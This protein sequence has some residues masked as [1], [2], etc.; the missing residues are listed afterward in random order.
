MDYVG[1]RLGNYRLVRPVGRGAFADVYLGEH[2]HL[3]TQAAVKVLHT[4]MTPEDVEK[5]R[6]E[7][8]L[9]VRLEHPHII[10]V[11]DFGVEKETIPFLVM[12]YAPNGTLRALYPRGTQLPLATVISYVK[13]IAPALQYAHYRKVIHRDIKPENILLGAHNEILL[14]DFGI[15]TVVQSTSSLSTQKEAGTIAYMAPEQ[16]R[17]KVGPAS[18]QYALGVL[19][20]EWLSGAR[21]F[22]GDSFIDV[23]MQHV[24]DAPPPLRES[25]PLLEPA[26][27]LV[28]MQ[29]LAKDPKD[30][31]PSVQAFAKALEQAG[32]SSQS[33]TQFMSSPII[34]PSPPEAFQEATVQDNQNYTS[35]VQTDTARLLQDA[36]DMYRRGRLD[37]AATLYRSVLQMDKTN[38]RA[39]QELGLVENQRAKYQDAL[40]SFECALQLNSSLIAALNGKATS[41]GMLQRNQEALET[42]EHVL[43]LDAQNITAWSGKGSALSLLQRHQ[44]ALASFEHVLQMEPDNA[45]A[46]NGKGI[47]LNA[48]AHPEQALAAFDMALH[49]QPQ[50]AQAWSNKGLIYLQQAR[51]QEAL[52][53]FEHA[54]AQDDRPVAYWRGKGA[55][56]L[57]QGHLKEALE[58]YQEALGRNPDYV[59]ALYGIGNV[60]AQQR[61]Y[62]AALDMYDHALLCDPRFVPALE[63]RAAILNDMGRLEESLAAYEQALRLHPRYAHAWSGKAS[64]LQQMQQY[65]QALAAYEQA[66]SINPTM[67]LVWNGKGNTLYQLGNFPGALSCYDQALRLDPGMA[68]ALHNK[69]LILISTRQYAEGLAAAEVAIQLAPD[70]P[71]N[72]QRKADALRK[73]GKGREA[74]AAEE[75]MKRLISRQ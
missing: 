25:L 59:P 51:N 61:K 11:L 74:R 57:A 5:F 33:S 38:A 45:F 26:V 71:D 55:T 39:W 46:W 36:R 19:V 22:E 9:L 50:M 30:R 48:L 15:A 32:M 44:E 42:Y 8:R 68:L 49:W 28:V 34:L 24:S 75:K 37:E 53:A 69:A 12:T 65:E 70:D 14:S 31:F 7:A 64:V 4:Q 52:E 63:K 47:A 27:E 62:K 10:R 1:Q 40:A 20:Y 60:L 56:L 13:Q 67:P 35:Q 23:A 43:L 72:W 2:I 17:G 16:L 6:S 18:D 3:E 29:A 66:L 21:P 58:A 73:L 54:L 41:L